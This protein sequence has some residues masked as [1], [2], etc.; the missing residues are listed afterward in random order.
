MNSPLSWKVFATL[1]AIVLVSASAG[2][3]A[4]LAT[5]Q[6][7]MHR[8]FDP[9]QWNVYAMNTLQK[10]LDLSEEQH[11]KI[12][13]IIDQTVEEM[14]VLHIDT[15]QRTTEIVDHLLKAIERELTPEQRK[16]ADTLSPSSEEVTIDLLKVRPQSK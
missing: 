13:E 11:T 1:F 15:V 12:Q 8:R 10:K 7:E 9:A 4:G 16:I 5:K 6:G 2:F 14:K 3:I